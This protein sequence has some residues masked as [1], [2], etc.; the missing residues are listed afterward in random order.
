[1]NKTDIAVLM[2]C[3][4]RRDKTLRSLTALFS[5]ELFPGVA[6]QVYLLDDGSTD[7]TAETILSTYPQVKIFQGNGS[8][9]WNGGMR[10][11]FAEAMK[12]ERDYYLWLNDDTELYPQALNILLA[13]H[14]QLSNQGYKETILVGAIQEPKTGEISHG[15]ICR[16]SLWHPLKF[17][18]VDPGDTLKPCDTMNGNCV[19]I[20]GSVAKLVGNLDPAFTH[21]IGD[22]D[23]GLRARQQG[24][25]IWVCPGYLGVCARNLLDESWMD[26]EVSLLERWKKVQQPK[27]LPPKEWKVFVKRHGGSL[28][29]IYWMFTYLRLLIAPQIK[30]RTRGVKVLK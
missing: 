14:R 10:L 30:K 2:T 23:Y 5:Q 3:H 20:P 25:T 28:W 24:C 6:V 4:N 7:G 26:P 29:F 11:V 22:F 15:G 12:M 17:G 21:G 13:S 19:L 9:F 27:G 18:L 1:M 8:M 16:T